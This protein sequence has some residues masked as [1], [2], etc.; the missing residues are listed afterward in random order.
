MPIQTTSLAQLLEA[1]LD[2]RHNKQGKLKTDPASG[3]AKLIEVAELSIRSEESKPGFALLLL[4][5]TASESFPYNTRLASAL[6][7]KNFI[8]RNWTDENGNY[9]LSSEDVQAIK[10]E[11]IGLMVV[12]PSKI[13]AQLGEAISVIADSDFWERWPTL[14]D[15]LVSRLTNDNITVNT[16]ILLVAHTIFRRWRPLFRSDALYTEINHVL[17]KFS[18]PYLAL[19][20]SLD[21]Y[22]DNN[23]SEKTALAQAFGEL[24]V[25]IQ[26]LFDLSCQDLP[27]VFED[28]LK[29]IAGLL[30]KYLMYDNEILHTDTEDEAGPLENVKANV[31]EVLV[32]YVQKYYDAFQEQVKNF[33]GSSWNLLTTVSLE[34]KNDILVSKAL[35]FLTSI[36]RINEEA[37][38][39]ED[40]ST[41]NQIVEKVILPNISL[42]DSD[43]EMFEDEPIE[44]IRRDLEGFDSE[45]RR[46][47]ATDFLR[48]LMTQFEELSTRVVMGYVEKYLQ[49]YQ[50][51]PSDNWRSKDISVYLF[52]SIAAKGIPTASHGVMQT[53]SLTDIGRFFQENLAGDLA[54]DTVHPLLKVDAIKYL[55][56]FR[57]LIT[58]EQWQQVLPALVN[59]LGNSNYVVYTYAAI[60]VERTLYLTDE[61]SKPIID[62]TA[63]TPLSKDLLVHIFSLIEKESSPQKIQENEFL[64]RCVMRVL[65]VIK[66]AIIPYTDIVLGHLVSILN[67]IYANPSNPRFY[68]YFFEALG[69]LIRYAGPTECAKLQEALFGPFV[70][71]LQNN[72]EGRF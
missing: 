44:Y 57:S 26:L 12:V 13:Q 30:H 6:F 20:Q 33:V 34:T 55:Y 54:S 45:T 35:G 64:I 71:I 29:S 49:H 17:G 62:P 31:F 63:I 70:T 48:Q 11:I 59:H 8:S 9:K 32:L 2:P 7:F 66:E 67:V 24:D 58:K 53:N 1:S 40:Q 23:K 38:A 39:F 42:R 50:T 43:I 56:L 46:R 19:W 37:K 60:A 22:I 10:T 68:Y 36:A 16:G 4:Q 15:D 65:I 52:C 21:V 28:N 51:S 25:I 3:R 69:A 5:I 72:V 47:A 27:P 18:Q 61:S 41:L 14:V